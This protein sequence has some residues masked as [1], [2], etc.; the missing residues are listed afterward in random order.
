[1]H[2]NIVKIIVVGVSIL[3]L[4]ISLLLVLTYVVPL[5]S[6]LVKRFSG[7]LPAMMIDGKIVSVGEISENV[8]ATR[9]FYENQNFSDVGIRIDFDTVDGQKRLK[10]VEREVI[11]NLAENIIIAD[12]VHK[13][14]GSVDKEAVA[15]ALSRTLEEGGDID[16]A[17][18]RVGLYGWSLEKFA[19]KIIK[20]SL[21]RERFEESFM[22]SNVA[23]EEMWSNIRAAKSM[24]DDGRSFSEAAEMYSEGLTASEGGT[25]G[26]Y[27]RD[28]LD[29]AIADVAFALEEDVPSDPFE[30]SYGLHL[31]L[32]DD[33]VFDEDG[34]K[35]LVS[36]NH[37]YLRKKSLTQHLNEE[38]ARRDIRIFLP[39]YA[40]D[41]DESYIVFTD[42]ELKAFEQRTIEE[43]QEAVRQT[44]E[45][46]V[47][48]EAATGNEA[49][50]ETVLDES[51]ASPADTSRE[52]Q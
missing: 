35:E 44:V 33:I 21:Y 46:I 36:L 1:M 26:L 48:E 38:F 51:V 13:E 17:K 15:M 49:L 45:E 20:P 30:T 8:R 40:W 41:A 52:V 37:I 14:G 11:N 2:K 18:E 23:S 32:V 28:Q 16:Y 22:R 24:I 9:H 50:P 39:G 5:D 3:L 31:L 19:R 25:L 4:S 6:P 27:S 34:V 29:S 43:A 10:I 42:D 12:I 7:I 47:A